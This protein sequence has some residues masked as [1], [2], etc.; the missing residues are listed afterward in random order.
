MKADQTITFG[1]LGGKAL[2]DPD[3]SVAATASSGLTVSLRL[4]HPERVHGVGHDRPPRQRRDLPIKADQAGNGSYNAAPSVSQS[5][6]VVGGGVS[7]IAGHDRYWTAAM[8]S[9]A[10]FDPGV[11]VVYI[12]TGQ[13]F[14]DALAAGPAAGHDGG[15]ILLVTKDSIPASVATE[16]TRLNPGRIVVLG[17]TGTI[18]TAVQTALG[19]Y[20]S[21][22]VTRI[23]G[24]DRYQTASLLSAAVFSL[25]T[26]TSST[27]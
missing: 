6:T 3:F 15:P 17:G 24:S 7:R 26:L 16:L 19:T 9:A 22:S 23:A 5:F 1:A 2:G 25:S 13:T 10:T 14:P 21:G 18:S 20:T 8:L 11:P 27:S 12:A 4:D